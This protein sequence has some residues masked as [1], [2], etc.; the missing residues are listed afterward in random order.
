MSEYTKKCHFR[1]GLFLISLRYHYS[2]DWPHT[3][4]NPPRIDLQRNRK[5]CFLQ[6]IN[7][8]ISSLA[9]SRPI[10]PAQGRRII[11][12]RPEIILPRRRKLQ[13]CCRQAD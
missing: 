5:R 6:H 1:Q 4:E 10:R 7:Q 9:V 12:Q 11:T 13:R 3:C 8:Q 2:R